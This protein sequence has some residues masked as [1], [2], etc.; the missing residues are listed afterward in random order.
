MDLEGESLVLFI[1]QNQ[2]EN[3]ISKNPL[4]NREK[5]ELLEAAN[6]PWVMEGVLCKGPLGGLCGHGS[7]MGM[8]EIM[9]KIFP[10]RDSER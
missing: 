10:S 5:N 9:K 1:L 6:K 7:L 2:Q 4:D 8:N 3:T